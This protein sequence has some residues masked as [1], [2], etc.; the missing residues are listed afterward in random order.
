MKQKEEK[1]KTNEAKLKKENQQKPEKNY[2]LGH[3]NRLRERVIDSPESMPSY[4]LLELLLFGTHPRNDTR[5]LSKKILDE[6]GDIPTAAHTDP[7]VLRGIYHFSDP[8]IAVLVA[9]KEICVRNAKNELTKKQLLNQTQIISNYAKSKI[10]FEEKE[11]LMVLFLDKGYRLIKDEIMSKGTTDYISVYPKE[12]TSKAL[13]LNASYVVLAHNH[14]SGIMTPSEDDFFMTKKVIE[15]LN[16][17]EIKVVDHIIVSKSS[18]LS[19]RENLIIDSEGNFNEDFD[20][21]S[22]KERKNEEE[23]KLTKEE[24]ESFDKVKNLYDSIIKNQK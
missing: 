22:I 21:G 11:I 7:Q 4:E 12:I 5:I 3:R 20:L 13:L 17:V 1:R 14:P 18:N 2:N 19:F 8:V 16:S 23:Q 9:L 15:S 6:F 24:K 10:G